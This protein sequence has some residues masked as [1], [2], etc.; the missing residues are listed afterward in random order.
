MQLTGEMLIGARAVFGTE[1]SLQAIDPATGAEMEPAFR[2][3]SAQHVDAA[4]TLTLAAFDPYRSTSLERRALFLEAIA[5]GITDLA[6]VLVER[7][8]AESGLPRP[9][10]EGERAR[11]VGQL[12]LFAS[13][14]REG[15]WLNVTFDTP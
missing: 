9:R 10:V 7:V 3:G 8:M 2:G 13:L 11:T 5:K 4:C 15:R 12:R 14:T 1:G 6:D